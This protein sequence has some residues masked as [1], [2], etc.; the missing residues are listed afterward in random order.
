MLKH[1][2]VNRFTH[3]VF[4]VDLL[5]IRAILYSR[6]ALL[7]MTIQH[8]RRR[9]ETETVSLLFFFAQCDKN[10]TLT[11]GGARIGQ[12]AR[13]GFSSTPSV[14]FT[15]PLSS[16]SLLNSLSTAFNLTGLSTADSSR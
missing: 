6:F 5:S 7:F 1:E 15:A 3:F 12:I 2:A 9:D 14:S 4:A 16:G 10:N 11:H 13:I 8:S